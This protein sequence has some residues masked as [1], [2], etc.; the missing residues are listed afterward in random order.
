MGILEQL[1]ARVTDVN[2]GLASG[3]LVRNVVVDHESD[4]L[5]RQRQQLFEGKNANNEDLRP[6]YSEDLQPGGYFKTPESAR[7]YADWKRQ[8]SYPVQAQRNPDAPNLYVAGVPGAGR[9]HSEL[10]VAFGPEALTILGESAY[11]QRII[12]KYG[13]DQFGISAGRWDDIFENCGALEELTNEIR[14]V[15]WQ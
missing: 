14:K 2:N 11:S 6:L 9:F 13:L 1:L 12:A 7:R 5:E 8:M 10:T 3:A 15:L 4:I